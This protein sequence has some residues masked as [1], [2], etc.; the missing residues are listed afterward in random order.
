MQEIKK[1]YKNGCTTKRTNL[2]KSKNTVTG[3]SVFAVSAVLIFAL[4]ASTLGLNKFILIGTGLINKNDILSFIGKDIVIEH[5]EKSPALSPPDK[6]IM[7]QRLPIEKPEETD[8]VKESLNSIT[9]T[10]D[11]IL[12]LMEK[13]S[14]EHKNDKKGGKIIEQTFSQK[15]AT[16][17]YKNIFVKNVTE[18]KK[19]NI[20]K[21]LSE[22]V[23]IKIEDKSKPTVLIFHTHTTE[24]Y[25]ILDRGFWAKGTNGRSDKAD[26]SVVRV[27]DEIENELKKAGFCVIHD[28]TIHDRKYTGAYDHSRVSVKDYLKKYPTIQ[29]VLD[30]HRDAIHPDDNNKIKPVTKIDGK[31]AAQVMIITGAEEGRVKNFPDWEYNL[32]FALKLQKTVCDMYPTI[33]RPVFFSQRKYVMDL[34]HNNVLIEMGSDVNTLEEAA[35]SGRLIGS[36]LS[37]MLSDYVV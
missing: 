2:F 18:T 20:E 36:A 29:V 16:D 32:R 4:T 13:F 12:K 7:S 25:E 21:V 15:G 31:K 3:I 35:Y 8:A 33:M 19:V 10:P 1:S 22:K 34:S 17:S 30:V 28:K 37:K 5:D 26:R 23:D 27:G 24:A 6:D 14:S 9:A 11:D